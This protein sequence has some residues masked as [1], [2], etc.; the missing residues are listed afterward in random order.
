MLVVRQSID[1]WV[2]SA[3]A[4]A[5]EWLESPSKRQRVSGDYEH[6][7][8]MLVLLRQR[9]GDLVRHVAAAL[10][11][12]LDA[13]T[14]AQGFSDRPAPVTADER[15]LRVLRALA[16]DQ[17]PAAPA[18]PAA[19][20]PALRL[21]L[22]SEAQIDSEIET[23][24]I[25]QQVEAEAE[26]ELQELAAL[27]SGLVGRPAVDPATVPLRPADCARAL[28]EAIDRLA[29]EAVLRPALLR[30]LGQTVAAQLR[31]VYASQ[32][33]WLQ[34]RGV[35]AASFRIVPTAVGGATPLRAD[36]VAAGGAFASPRLPEPAES[37]RTLVERNRRVRPPL[38]AGADPAAP[39]PAAAAADA[40]ANANADGP[41]SLRLL[42]A[43]RGFDADDGPLP[44][45]VA[46]EMMRGLFAELHRE[47]GTTPG[48]AEFLKRLDRLSQRV[49]AADPA[50]WSDPAHPWWNLLDR[51]LASGAVQDDLSPPDRRVLRRSLDEAMQR[52]EEAPRLDDPACFA[53]ADEAHLL[54]SRL[55]ENAAEPPAEEIDALQRL[56]ERE[57]LEATFRN[58]IVQQLRSTPTSTSM[59]RFLV[60]PWTLVLVAAA[61]R[62]GSDG[63]AVAAAAL[64][65]DDLIRATAQ[66]GRGVSQAQRNVLLRQVADGLAA[67]GM[68]PERRQAELAELAALLDDPPPHPADSHEPWAEDRV[69]TLPV[70]F[71]LDLHAGLPTVPLALPEGT[72]VE[73]AAPRATPEDWLDGLQAGACCRLF[74]QGR[75]MTVRLHWVGPGHR[76]F[77]FHSR[78]GGRSHSLTRR[79][80]LKLR[81]AGLATSI[82]D[83]LLRAQAM[84]SLVRA[85]VV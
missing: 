33:E 10:R 49:A 4:H 78:Q 85:T 67:A 63:P 25:V 29:P 30:L 82:E 14:T 37:M 53:A 43:P 31:P 39:G 40:N 15:A 83:S 6:T 77:L 8:A 2:E 57:E 72:A 68:P 60:G 66:P 41:L 56:A 7:A 34:L 17:T 45:A 84:D 28:A 75:W 16:G 27:C 55:L 20:A 35:S 1:G 65:V 73:H 79:M 51:L 52:V 80:L 46:E 81:E 69:E 42:D 58:Q 71:T 24:R 11:E 13:H 21:T 19:A 70:P 76:L 62:G 3:V 12:H 38:E 26:G 61:E 36:A 47:A 50:L 22:I 74:L 44:R 5:L 18:A 59:R 23:A 64:V 32:I 54:A 48:M 9:R